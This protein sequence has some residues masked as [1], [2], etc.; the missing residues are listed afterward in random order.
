MMTTI[1]LASAVRTRARA[2][3]WQQLMQLQRC[4]F[5]QCPAP[6]AGTPECL[7]RVA[8]MWFDGSAVP[9]PG[10]GGAGYTLRERP[11]LPGSESAP[12]EAKKV[13]D[14]TVAQ[15]KVELKARG[16]P[17]GGKKAELLARLVGAAAERQEPVANEEPGGDGKPGLLLA[18]VA[19]MITGVAG[20]KGA[21]DG[22]SC[23]M[24]EYFALVSGLKEA[25]RPR[26][27]I[28]VLTVLGDSQLVIRQLNGHYQVGPSPA[29]PG[30]QLPLRF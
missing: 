27:N 24:A 2:S 20:R 4:G 5:A 26:H 8:T 10:H 17:V 22:V 29:A 7:G 28:S 9:N 12:G 30:A 21:D 1:Q 18:E 14:R 15:L 13:K 3:P 23:N 6:T 16:L 19:L 25:S 11:Q